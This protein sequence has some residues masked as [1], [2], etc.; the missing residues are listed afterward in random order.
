MAGAF[1]PN[2]DLA[3]A[4]GYDLFHDSQAEANPIVVHIRV[5]MQPA[6]LREQLW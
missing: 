6:K 1:R 4:F 5:P 2:R 3:T